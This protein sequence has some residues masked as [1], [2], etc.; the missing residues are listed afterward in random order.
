MDHRIHVR[1]ATDEDWP[2]IWQALEPV[3]RAGETYTYPRDITEDEART[4]WTGT[5]GARV[6]VAA[7][8]AD[9]RVLGTAKYLPNHPG[10]GAHVANASFV[11]APDAGGRGVGRALGHAVLDGARAEGYRAMVFNAVVETNDRAVALWRSLGFT[12]LATVPEAFDHPTHGLVG[13]HI[14]HRT[15]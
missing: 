13:L 14:M 11:V 7:D 3:L 6:L 4:V 8:A 15:L 10:A 1:R 12:V 5:P 9:G 2:G